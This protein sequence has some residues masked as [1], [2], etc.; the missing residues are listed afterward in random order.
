MP[1]ISRFGCTFVLCFLGIKKTATNWPVLGEATECGQESLQLHWFRAVVKFYNSL[2][3]SI[4]ETL[5]KVLKSD[6]YLSSV[7][8]S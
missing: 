4:S 5:R 1:T 6:V 3:A 8:K 7:D 2:R